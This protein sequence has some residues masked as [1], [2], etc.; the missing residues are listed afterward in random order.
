MADHPT[1]LDVPPLPLRGIH[2][3]QFGLYEAAVSSVR[4][5]REEME[6]ALRLRNEFDRRSFLAG[7]RAL[8]LLLAAY[9][10]TSASAVH[11]V[12]RPCP[13]CGLAHGKP[14][15]APPHEGMF[16]NASRCQRHLLIAVSAS[17]EVGVDLELLGRLP[18]LRQLAPLVASR[19][20]NAGG[21]PGWPNDRSVLRL[22]TRKEAAVK[23]AGSG[24]TLEV[25]SFSASD[26]S[27][28]GWYS[29]DGTLCGYRVYDLPLP[30]PL[31]GSVAVPG[32]AQPVTV[33]DGRRALAAR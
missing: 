20:E 29:T 22:W 18:D 21:L 27:G 13:V 7:R 16:F 19:R 2:V 8:R 12:R 6:R 24:L 10:D 25:T 9:L 33:F 31:V 17:S 23:A 4:L 15:L 26:D 11:F 5:E 1:T 28:D 32:V 3:W 30:Q 14:E